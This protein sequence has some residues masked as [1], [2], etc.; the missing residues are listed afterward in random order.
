[1]LTDMD[2]TV[3]IEFLRSNST[4]RGE[5]LFLNEAAHL[6][7]EDSHGPYTLVY[8]FFE[9]SWQ[10]LHLSE[11]AT[12][13]VATIS[14]SGHREWLRF[15]PDL[16]FRDA[17]DTLEEGRW[18]H[19]DVIAIQDFLRSNNT[20]GKKLL[21][22]DAAHLVVEDSYGSYTLVYNVLELSWQVLRCRA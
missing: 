15:L 10:V 11:A 16:M 6:V 21:L 13:R 4:V 7:V 2:V 9:P 19:D 8:N 12:L 5:K 18:T 22:N 3:I 1:M 14:T 20:R 17:I